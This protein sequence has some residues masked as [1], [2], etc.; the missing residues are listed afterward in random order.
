MSLAQSS[1]EP[2]L[3]KPSLLRSASLAAD[4]ECSDAGSQGVHLPKIKQGSSS[5]GPGNYMWKDDV[6]LKGQ[7]KWTLASPERKNLDLMC[8]SWTPTPTSNM[9]RAPAATEYSQIDY[10]KAVGPKGKLGAPKFS[11]NKS[12]PVG[13]RAPD[14]P[15]TFEVVNPHYGMVG[16]RH[17]SRSMPPVWTMSSPPRNK[18]PNDNPTWQPRSSTDLRPG[19]GE[20]NL[21]RPTGPGQ[22]RS[23][24]QPTSRKGT[25]GGRPRNLHPGD[26][27][28]TPTTHGSHPMDGQ[29]L[30]L[31]KN[32]KV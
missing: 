30:R 32:K 3:S 6:N 25:F 28:W 17:P 13:C 15:P 12:P 9:I 2:V 24:W 27:S 16:G 5:P 20:Y 21:S 29:Y 23:K 26:T 19:P 22:R 7:P 31:R 11:I 10:D 4:G 8:P 18:L 1:S 14:A